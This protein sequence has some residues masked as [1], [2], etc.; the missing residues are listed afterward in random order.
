M[1]QKRYWVRGLG[2]GVVMSIIAIASY[3]FSLGPVLCADPMPGANLNDPSFGCKTDFQRSITHP[4]AFFVTPTLVGL[5]V[6]VVYGKV[7]NRQ[8]GMIMK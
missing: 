6:G 5:F 7:R 4:L 2:I 8:R 3:H 1:K